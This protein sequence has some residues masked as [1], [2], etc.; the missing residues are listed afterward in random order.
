M[1]RDSPPK[2][3]NWTRNCGQGV[4]SGNLSLHSRMRMAGWANTS[5]R[6]RVSKSWKFSR[7][8][9]SPWNTR[10]PVPYSCKR[11]NV[12]LVTSSS[13]AAWRPATMPLVK[14]V[15]PV[16]S[17]PLSRT[18][19]G[20]SS[21]SPRRRPHPMVSSAEWV[22]TSS[23]T[24]LQLLQQP[25]ARIGDHLR[26]FAGQYPRWFARF[27]EQIGR[28]PVEINAQGHDAEQI[29]RTKL[30]DERAKQTREDVARPAFRQCRAPGRVHEYPAFG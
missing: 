10:W 13:L 25:A 3:S 17:S 21:L 12:G 1:R 23:A 19:R 27:A 24:L 30:A 5:S 18:R 29:A 2:C 14:V 6:P 28:E 26:H 20:G 9:R 7:R 11:V 8:Y 22:T 16:P 15:L 4:F